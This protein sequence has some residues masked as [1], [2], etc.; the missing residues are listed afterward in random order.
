MNFKKALVTGGN[1]N[2]GRLLARDLRELGVSTVQFDIPGSE[3]EQLWTDEAIVTGDIRDTA[4][5]EDIFNQHKPDAV[6]HLASLLSGSSEANVSDAWDINATSSFKLIELAAGRKVERFFF[7]STLATYGAGVADPLPED[8]PQWPDLFYGVT[9]VAVERLGVYYK[10]KHALDF[11]CLRFPLVLSPYAPPGALTAYPSHA[12]KAAMRGETRFEFP[13][14]G[15]IGTST[16]FLDD[17]IK[18][19]VDYT[20]V[21]AS[22]LSR[23]VYSLHSYILTGHMVERAIQDRFPEFK[24]DY[25]PDAAAERML[26]GLPDVVEDQFARDD[27]QWSPDFDFDKTVNAMFELF[28]RE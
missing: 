6:F 5:I 26:G 10:L 14:S 17:V 11:R 18:S 28:A 16:L 4:L 12:F 25:R 24:A 27:W 7:A 9:K 21:D 13:V 22:Q 20:K 15:H 2:L 3:P 1:G 23:H 19:I 8:E